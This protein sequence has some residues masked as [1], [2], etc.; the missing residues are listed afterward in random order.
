[1]GDFHVEPET[2]LRRKGSLT[3]SARQLPLLLMDTSMIVE[4]GRNTKGLATVVATVAPRLRVDAAVVLQGKQ[5]GVG[6]EAHSTVVDANSVGVLVVEEG[7]G[8]AVGA[9]TLITSVQRK[10]IIEKKVGR[11]NGVGEEKKGRKRGINNRIWL[12]TLTGLAQ[13]LVTTFSLK[14]LKI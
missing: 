4:L 7:A 10:K 13:L 12:F 11:T 2:G 3:G 5:V 14:L 1:M 8:M 9:T 6:F